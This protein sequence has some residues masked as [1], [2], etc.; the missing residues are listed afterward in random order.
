MKRLI[1]FSLATILI[2][3]SLLNA[4]YTW[5][6][7]NGP[8]GGAVRTIITDND[9]RIFAASGGIVRSM[10]GGK[11]WQF[12]TGILY[13]VI[14]FA[15]NSE[16]YI[17]AGTGGG[18]GVY[19]STDHGD[20]WRQITSGLPR[21]N[22]IENIVNHSTGQLLAAHS[23]EGIFL[24]FDGGITWAPSNNGLTE[25]SVYSL[26][27]HSDGRI[28]AG[29]FRGI[30][31]STDDGASWTKFASFPDKF[32]RALLI[33]SQGHIFAGTEGFGAHRST[34]GGNTWTEI[35]AGLPD[36]ARVNCIV[37]DHQGNMFAVAN[38]EIY[39]SADNGAN[40]SQINTGLPD[41]SSFN[42]VYI[43][44]DG[45]LFAASSWGLYRSQ[46]VG[47]SWE[48]IGTP[49]MI[50]EDIAM[51]AAGNI[52]AATTRG[53]F[54]AKVGD[55]QWTFDPSR[56]PAASWQRFFVIDDDTIYA[57]TSSGLFKSTNGGNSWNALGLRSS[58]FSLL[59]DSQHDWFAG[60]SY[61]VT[62]NPSEEGG[63][64]RSSDRGSNW[65][66]VDL[67]GKAVYALAKDDSGHFFAGAG[68]LFP[69]FPLQGFIYRSRDNGNTWQQI[70][71]L[72]SAVYVLAIAPNSHLFAGTFKGI[73]RSTDRGNRWVFA[74]LK[75][76]QVRAVLINQRGNI[77]V[78]ASDG[79]YNSTDDGNSWR[80]IGLSGTVTSSLS[81]D[82]NGHLYAGT[83]GQGIF[84]ADPA[85]TLVREG[86]NPVL[87]SGFALEQ[88]YPNPFNPDT[89]IRFEL[90]ISAEVKLAILDILG[91]E[92]ATLVNGHLHS[93]HYKINWNGAGFASGV[94][95][96]RLQ[97]GEFTQTRKML[98]TK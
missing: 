90:P 64:Y 12:A 68:K 29:T 37:E 22:N 43:N 41:F 87:P 95:F 34:D 75:N 91:H 54:R 44:A 40:W 92:V 26:S 30:F 36:F 13:G 10:D 1:T 79:V 78:A 55:D 82:P 94:Y 67:K 66:Y 19:R 27:I 16:E 77:F 86:R 88:N 84:R 93:G 46:N 98:L 2:L 83:W 25:K 24:S 15:V 23:S 60:V 48:K 8:F 85:T 96:Y 20:T 14:C 5:K 39:R 72:D 38:R 52:W 80:P 58:V 3:S 32:V 49:N 97:T 47:A 7:T 33:N 9:G 21:Y 31:Y 81:F 28:F 50:V 57:G 71:V 17:L 69:L 56:Q 61:F 35:N 73:Y 18:G 63:I 6:S 65:A 4:Q 89:R 76:K 11:N 45:D 62:T 42:A 70:A 74:G 59:I 51:T 53:V